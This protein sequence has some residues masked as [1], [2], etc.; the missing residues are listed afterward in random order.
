MKGTEADEVF[1]LL[2]EDDLFGDDID[3]VGALADFVDGVWMD[4]RVTH[5]GVADWGRATGFNTKLL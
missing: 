2:L 1:A 3:D 5:G 4:A